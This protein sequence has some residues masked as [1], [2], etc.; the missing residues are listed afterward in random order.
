M[1]LRKIKF[2]SMSFQ[3]LKMRK[4]MAC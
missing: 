3:M 2:E 4:K 1:K